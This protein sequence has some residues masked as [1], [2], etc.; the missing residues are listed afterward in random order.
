LVLALHRPNP[1]PRTFGY[2]EIWYAATIEPAAC[3]YGAIL[4]L[5]LASDQQQSG[6]VMSAVPR[7][8]FV[9]HAY[10]AGGSAPVLPIVRVRHPNVS[11]VVL[12]ASG[13]RSLWHVHLC[14]G[15]RPDAPVG[16]RLVERTPERRRIH[17]HVPSEQ[18]PP[19]VPIAR[20]KRVVEIDQDGARHAGRIGA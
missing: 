2:H 1:S 17:T 5:F 20:D 7:Q 11:V 6:A 16:S 12:G 18:V 8:P 13:L 14:L 15:E 19:Q 9:D 10:L 3:L 4:S